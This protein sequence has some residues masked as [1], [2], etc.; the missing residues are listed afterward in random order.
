M[1]QNKN[2]LYLFNNIFTSG[3]LDLLKPAI[4]QFFFNNI[5]LIAKPKPLLTPLIITIFFSYFN[6]VISYF[7]NLLLIICL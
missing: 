2:F 1:F 5:L 3:L 7:L 4:I 6:I